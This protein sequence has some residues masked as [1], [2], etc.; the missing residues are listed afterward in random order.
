MSIPKVVEVAGIS[1]PSVSAA[2]RAHHI[3]ASLAS[4]RLKAGWIAEEAFGV[5]RR[6]REKKPRRQTWVVT[7]I[8]YPS[9]AEAARAH[10]LSPSA[11]RRRMKKGSN[12][13]EALRLGNPRNAGTGKEVMVNGITYANY[14]DVAK[15]H[16]IPYSNFLGRFTRYGWTLEQALDIEPRP[17]S[18]RGTWGRIY[19]IQH[20]A[21]GKIYIGVTQSSIDNRW[22]QHVDAA[23]QG[24]GKSPDS[25]QLAIRTYGE[26][27]FIQEEIGIA[28]S[29]GN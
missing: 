4:F 15:A 5:R 21:S 18:P 2:A 26:K 12:I 24:K 14:R 19:K 8:G 22:R 13:E 28:S 3:D 29:S 17:D 11:V 20:I 27:A 16:G 10:G 1:F 7:G 9:L 6:V 25:L 23:N